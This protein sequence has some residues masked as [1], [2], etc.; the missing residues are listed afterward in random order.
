MTSVVPIAERPAAGT[1]SSGSS[2]KYPRPKHLEEWFESKMTNG[3]KVAR[4][5]ARV[6]VDE[7]QPS[8]EKSPREGGRVP[9][10]REREEKQMENSRSRESSCS[11]LSLVNFEMDMYE[12][13]V[14]NDSSRDGKARLLFTFHLHQLT[15]YPVTP[16][17]DSVRDSKE[18]VKGR[19]ANFGTVM[20]GFYRSGYPQTEDHEYL[21]SL[22]LKT[23]L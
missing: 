17:L 12:E 7:Y 1:A 5:S 4:R 3:G 15:G 10:I 16:G 14:S 20:P 22:G 18:K 2:E 6:F 23:I 11:S 8:Q 9:A 21:R 13:V 19:P